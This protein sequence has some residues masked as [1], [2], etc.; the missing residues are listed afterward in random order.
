MYY[1]FTYIIQYVFLWLAS[2]AQC[3][4]MLCLCFI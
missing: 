4:A 3:Y 2:L 1:V